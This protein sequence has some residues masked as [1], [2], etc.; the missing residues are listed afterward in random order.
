VLCA[1]CVA[2]GAS[3]IKKK[4]KTQAGSL[5]PGAAYYTIAGGRPRSDGEII[6]SV[7]CA[8]QPLTGV[9]KIVYS[10]HKVCLE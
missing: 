10:I 7:L 5:D 4:K 8:P 3:F 2:N 1:V 6:K 9:I